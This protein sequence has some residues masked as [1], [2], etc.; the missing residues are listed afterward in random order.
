MSKTSRLRHLAIR[1]MPPATAVSRPLSASTILNIL[2]RQVESDAS[3]RLADALSLHA[4]A[5]GDLR[6]VPAA[7]TIE[8]RVVAPLELRLGLRIS[9]RGDD[10]FERRQGPA[11]HH[12]KS[13]VEG[14]QPR[15]GA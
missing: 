13:V 9:E 3:Q 1:E 8:R 12:A 2:G 6:D 5:L 15:L 14:E 11:V 7:C 4:R 10:R